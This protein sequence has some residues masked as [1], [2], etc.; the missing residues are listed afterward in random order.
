[1]ESCLATAQYERCGCSNAKY[2]WFVGRV[3]HSLEERK[4]FIVTSTDLSHIYV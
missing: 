2:A 1:M 3:C 4:Y